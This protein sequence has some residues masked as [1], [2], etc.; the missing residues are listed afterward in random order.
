MRLR[1][2]LWLLASLFSGPGIAQGITQMGD[3]PSLAGVIDLHTQ[4]QGPLCRN[5]TLPW[6][7][8]P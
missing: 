1:I 4:P 5:A 3:A 8:C 2:W 6:R 7:P